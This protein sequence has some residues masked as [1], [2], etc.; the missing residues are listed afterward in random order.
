M[1]LLAM[2]IEYEI[3]TRFPILAQLFILNVLRKK[4]SP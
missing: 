4:A 3:N 2:E 1:S